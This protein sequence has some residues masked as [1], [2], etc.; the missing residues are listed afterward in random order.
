[1]DAMSE[2]NIGNHLVLLS[3]LTD[4]HNVITTPC[5]LHMQLLSIREVSSFDAFLFVYPRVC[6][7]VQVFPTHSFARYGVST[8]LLLKYLSLRY[9]IGDFS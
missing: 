8:C 9:E 6:L 1:M 5:I 7:L 3:S 4:S 2:T